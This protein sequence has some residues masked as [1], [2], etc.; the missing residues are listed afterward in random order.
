MKPGTRC[1][2]RSDHGVPLL[3][4]QGHRLTEPQ[5]AHDAVRLVTVF[6]IPFGKPTIRAYANETKVAMCAACAE[7]H[8]KKAVTS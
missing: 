5:C 2:C 4:D 1:E 8:E 3:N 7:Y 6:T